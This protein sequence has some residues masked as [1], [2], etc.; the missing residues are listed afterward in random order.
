MELKH[1]RM[2][3]LKCWNENYQLSI[4]YSVKISFNN[5]EKI[6]I[7]QIKECWDDLFSAE[8]H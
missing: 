3:S 5:E 1:N 7:F 6:K 2:T 4:A 8:I